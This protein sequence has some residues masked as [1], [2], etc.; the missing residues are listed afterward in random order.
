MAVAHSISF[1]LTISLLV[2][3]WHDEEDAQIL[4]LH[5]IGQCV[6]GVKAFV[7][8]VSTPRGV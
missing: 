4:C 2:G 1:F 3:R 7:R 5:I 6:E 8:Q